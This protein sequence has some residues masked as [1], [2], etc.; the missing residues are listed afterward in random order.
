MTQIEKVA[1]NAD[2]MRLL[3]EAETSD[4]HSLVEGECRR[5]ARAAGRAENLL[6][7]LAPSRVKIGNSILTRIVEELMRNALRFSPPQSEISVVARQIDQFVQLD[8]TNH[9]NTDLSGH[10]TIQMRRED[11]EAVLP[12]EFNHGFGLKVAH[13]LTALHGGQLTIRRPGVR[14]V[15][16]HLNLP[17]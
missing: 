15:C 10:T 1:A 7:D 14:K 6:L 4:L 8:F 16:V 13:N 12:V 17:A 3:P 9:S 5:L 2:A 11:F